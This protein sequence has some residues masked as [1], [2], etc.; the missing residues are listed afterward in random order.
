MERQ[1]GWKEG[2]REKMK[3]GEKK[4]G[5]RRIWGLVVL[6]LRLQSLTT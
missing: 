3:E 2:E 4:K 6:F 5:Q 1:M